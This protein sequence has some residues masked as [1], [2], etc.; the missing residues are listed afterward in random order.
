MKPRFLPRSRA[1]GLALAAGLYAVSACG[2]DAAPDDPPAGTSST[3]DA[4]SD[5]R[6]KLMHSCW[7][8]LVPVAGVAEKDL[9]DSFDDRRGT[10]RAHEAIDILA[11]RGT[12]VVAV[13]DGAVVKLFDSKPGGLTVYQFDPTLT[14]GYYYAH[15][16]RYAAGLAEGQSLKRGDLVGYVGSSGNADPAAPHLHFA[17]FVLGPERQWWKG[18][19]INPR[20]LFRTHAEHLPLSPVRAGSP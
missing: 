7:P 14:L 20:P 1:L 8:L 18:T 15:L 11:P 2:L 19:A 5:E 4:M 12:E 13:D 17:V 3:P 16:D 6:L 9:V 10:D